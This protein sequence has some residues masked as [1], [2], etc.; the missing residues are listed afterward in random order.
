MGQ[1]RAAETTTDP[2]YQ[3][4]RAGDDQVGKS[5]GLLTATGPAASSGSDDL[6]PE[7]IDAAKRKARINAVV[8]IMVFLLISLAPYPW[9]IFAPLLFLVPVI[10]SISNRVR[11]DGA[12]L[13]ALPDN[14]SVPTESH[15]SAVK[16][17]Y[18]CAPKD[19]N[20]PRR[21]K[22]IH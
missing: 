22:P 19:P 12:S 21:Y 13:D 5:D 3:E 6:P 9:N 8:L 1:W 15:D 10:L 2:V 17:P 16:E 4:M 18:S 11:R 7:Q 20:D 14:T